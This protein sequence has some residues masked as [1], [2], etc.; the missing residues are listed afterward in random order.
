M[1]NRIFLVGADIAGD[2][3]PRTFLMAFQ[4]GCKIQHNDI[5]LDNMIGLLIWNKSMQE[6]CVLVIQRNRTSLRLPA[7]LQ[8]RLQCSEAGASECVRSPR[9]ARFG[10]RSS[11][12]P[13]PLCWTSGCSA[14]G[15]RRAA[16]RVRGPFFE[17]RRTEREEIEM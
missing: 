9:L 16:E 8:Y 14:R 11:S 2:Q 3:Q 13:R 6:F 7:P 1:T 17:W 4:S 5:E 12:L 15:A 10:S